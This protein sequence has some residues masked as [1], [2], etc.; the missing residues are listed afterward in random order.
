MIQYWAQNNARRG[1]TPIPQTISGL[2]LWLDASDASSITL[3]GSSNV[4]QWND[5]S[6][7][8]KHAA[9]AVT[10]NRPSYPSGRIGGLPAVLFD[11][12]NDGLQVAS[13]TLPV[14]L[15]IFAV[16]DQ[17]NT[18]QK[19]FLIEHS[20]D[21]NF[22]NGMFLYA[23]TPYYAV[24]RN[25]DS[26]THGVTGLPFYSTS[27]RQLS[28]LADTTLSPSGAIARYWLNGSPLTPDA[29]SG[30]TVPNTEVTT[31]LNIGARNGGA[32]VQFDGA[33]GEVI[34][35]NRPLG[36]TERQTI[37]TYLKTKWGTP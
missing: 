21:T 12:T 35:Y 16:F 32:S 19:W 25:P 36:T 7:N 1:T 26:N 23:A 28:F 31:T 14:S 10:L 24:R 18:N 13:M 33:M 37:E 11:G 30:T 29:G 20:A 22:N 6:G 17:D 2:A 5:K 3:D 15:T 4:S 8:G 27:A 9:Q 34:I